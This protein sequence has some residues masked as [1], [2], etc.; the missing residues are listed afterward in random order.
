M[1]SFPYQKTGYRLIG[2][3]AQNHQSI[4]S[5]AKGGVTITLSSIENLSGFF[6]KKPDNLKLPGH[7]IRLSK[8]TRPSYPAFKKHPASIRL[9]KNTA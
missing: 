7:Y 1:R 4:V 8:N 6:K 9:S 2:S 3:S 5:S